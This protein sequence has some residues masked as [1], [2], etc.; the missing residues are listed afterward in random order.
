MERGRKTEKTPEAGAN[1]AD[2]FLK[3]NN[4]LTRIKNEKDYDKRLASYNSIKNTIKDEPDSE[5]CLRNVSQKM[6][7]WK[8]IFSSNEFY[9]L[10]SRLKNIIKDPKQFEMLQ[11]YLKSEPSFEDKAKDLSSSMEGEHSYKNFLA[12]A[13]ERRNQYADKE[14]YYYIPIWDKFAIDEEITFS[15]IADTINSEGYAAYEDLEEVLRILDETTLNKNQIIATVKIPKDCLG[16]K[17]AYDNGYILKM[18]NN[19]I[20]E[21]NISEYFDRSKDQTIRNDEKP[22]PRFK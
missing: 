19:K 7:Q 17:H 22:S 6:E 15:E 10:L 12:L 9:N 2:I 1:I 14:E 16:T 18:K 3:L 8:R 4:Y 5:I 13:S 11:V 20:T 21:E